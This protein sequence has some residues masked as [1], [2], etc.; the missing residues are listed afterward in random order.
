[1]M[2]EVTAEETKVLLGIRKEHQKSILNSSHHSFP[3][4]MGCDKAEV[5]KGKDLASG[6]VPSLL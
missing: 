3:L 2:E 5:E 6:G 1:M 4:P